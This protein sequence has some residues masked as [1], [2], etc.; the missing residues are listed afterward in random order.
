M[1][2]S[3]EMF[4]ENVKFTRKPKKKGAKTDTYTVTKDGNIVGQ[5]KWSSRVMGYAFTPT[6]DCENEVKEF[7]RGLMSERRKK[8]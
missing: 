5:I 4:N 2:Q 7:V 6:P 8:K 1:I 3:F